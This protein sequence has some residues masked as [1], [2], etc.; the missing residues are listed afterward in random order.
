MFG[1]I[2]SKFKKGPP[3]EARRDP[4]C[5]MAAREEM[6]FEYEGQIYSFCS[7]HCRQRFAQEPERYRAK[8]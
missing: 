6:T 5:G 7:E 4:V 2:F 3:V 8:R 1:S